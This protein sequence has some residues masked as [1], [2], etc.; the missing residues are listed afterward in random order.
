MTV[1]L[2]AFLS[3]FRRRHFQVKLAINLNDVLCRL[4]LV[5]DARGR[6]VCKFTFLRV[7]RE[8][9]NCLHHDLWYRDC[10]G[11]RIDRFL[12]RGPGYFWVVG[13]VLRDWILPSFPV[14]RDCC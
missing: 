2:Q 8:R 11:W 12:F 1:G 10:R 6:F 4:R 5:L 13:F 7:V 9:G 14:P 3:R